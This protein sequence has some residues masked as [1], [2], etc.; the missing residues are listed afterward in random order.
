[1]ISK[2]HTSHLIFILICLSL[3]YEQICG[4]TR[5]QKKLKSQ[6]KFEINVVS[7]YKSQIS[8]L[9]SPSVI[10]EICNYFI[11]HVFSYYKET[12]NQKCKSYNCSRINKNI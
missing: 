4:I 12:Q 7:T 3:I 8:I 5:S 6:L 11:P 2:I 9:F 1:M 10:L